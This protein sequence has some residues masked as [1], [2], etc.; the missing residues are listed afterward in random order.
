MQRCT[1]QRAQLTMYFC[2]IRA[3]CVTKTFLTHTTSRCINIL[4]VTT[5]TMT[6]IL[7]DAGDCWRSLRQWRR[8]D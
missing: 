4:S 3:A 6:D 8:V 2:Q 7:Y 1:V 5:I